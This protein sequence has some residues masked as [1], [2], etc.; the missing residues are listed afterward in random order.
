MTTGESKQ[1]PKRVT[2]DLDPLDYESLRDWAYQER[3]SHSD[4]LR[5]L[6]HLLA[7]DPEV[8]SQVRQTER[9]A[10]S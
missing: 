2:V 9:Q 5:V 4:V 1:R 7:N 6:V 8:A 10:K 3:M